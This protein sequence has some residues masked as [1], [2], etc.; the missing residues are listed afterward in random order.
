M[1]ISLFLKYRTAIG[2]GLGLLAVTL[3][4]AAVYAAGYHKAAD[5]Y[6][7]EKAQLVADYQT[8][9][10]QAEQAYSA[11]LA[12]AAAEKQRWFDYAQTQ[13]VQLADAARQ[14][15]ARQ[16][17]LKQEIPHAVQRDQNRSACRP[18]LGAD[19]LHLYRQALGYP[20]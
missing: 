8:A 19:S 3:L 20:D 9:A 10:L 7:T 4:A 18:G 2:W 13:S 17:Y 14:L 11:K 15:D 12:Q 5:K 1:P 6:Q 16:G